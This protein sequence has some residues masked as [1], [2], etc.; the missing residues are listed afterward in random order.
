ME[1]PEKN[2]HI[3]PLVSRIEDRG[4]GGDGSEDAAFLREAGVT[5]Q[6][7]AHVAD[8][9]TQEAPATELFTLM[10]EAL[11]PPVSAPPPR[12]VGQRW[13]AIGLVVLCLLTLAGGFGAFFWQQTRVDALRLQLDEM[14][15]PLEQRAALAEG[16]A[17]QLAARVASLEAD[18]ATLR[19]ALANAESRAA[20]LAAEAAAQ[21]LPRQVQVPPSPGVGRTAQADESAIAP[22]DN[23]EAVPIVSGEDR[24]AT[25]PAQG[26][27]VNLGTFG[28]EAAAAQWAQGMENVPGTP[29]VIPVQ[30]GDRTLYRVR[31]GA[32]DSLAAAREVA[33]ELS[34]RLGLSGV[35]VSEG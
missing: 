16:E 35:W 7:P 11:E 12:E 22:A 34:S 18:R 8:A 3:S 14:R 24:A 4:P 31:V 6:P 29:Q 23:E 15:Q 9:A 30:R 26:W 33:T 21:A 2:V 25:S 17:E 28:K 1:E 10:P 27:F 20:Q 32:F 13:P 5:A 19:S